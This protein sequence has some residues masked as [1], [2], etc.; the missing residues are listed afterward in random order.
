LCWLYRPSVLYAHVP[1]QPARPPPIHEE[2]WAWR[3]EGEAKES[4][5]NRDKREERREAAG[6]SAMDIRI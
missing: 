4:R 5:K 3:L 1:Q 2:V 6:E